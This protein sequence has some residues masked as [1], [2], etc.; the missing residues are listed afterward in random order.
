[1][2]SLSLFAIVFIGY[3]SDPCLRLCDM[4]GP[5]VCTNGSYARDGHICHAYFRVGSNGHCYHTSATRDTCPASLPPLTV[6]EAEAIVSSGGG[7]VVRT[8]PRP[9]PARIV[10]TT[11]TR[12]TVQGPS[13]FATPTAAADYIGA[14]VTATS[15]D[16]NTLIL[17]IGIAFSRAATTSWPSHVTEADAIDFWTRAGGAEI[18]SRTR[19]AGCPSRQCQALMFLLGLMPLPN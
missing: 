11:T 14:I 19:S 16:V 3:A 4:D 1:M 13:E 10:Y 15:N 12:P 6:R 18:F 5:D 8:T 17:A 7:P 2:K 9:T